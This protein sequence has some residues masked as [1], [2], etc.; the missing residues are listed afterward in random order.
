MDSEVYGNFSPYAED[1]EVRKEISANSFE[2]VSQEDIRSE[3]SLLWKQDMRLIPP[4][5]LI[6][7]QTAAIH[8]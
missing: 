5:T 1:A 3:K 8:S 4:W 2:V 6:D 7:L